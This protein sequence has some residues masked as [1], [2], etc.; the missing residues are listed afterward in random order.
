MFTTPAQPPRRIHQSN[1]A[2]QC[3][4]CPSTCLGRFTNNPRCPNHRWTWKSSVCFFIQYHLKPVWFHPS[5]CVHIKKHN[6]GPLVSVES[7]QHFHSITIYN[8][9]LVWPVALSFLRL[10]KLVHKPVLKVVITA[11]KWTALSFYF[12]ICL[13][14]VDINQ[15]LILT[16]PDKGFNSCQ[17]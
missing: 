9:V 5:N 6:S 2:S 14:Q 3:D 17:F 10:H 7:C 8:S 11:P 15:N 4:I 13:S 16:E 12:Y 1:N